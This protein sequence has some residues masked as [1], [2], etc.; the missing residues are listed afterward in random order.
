MQDALNHLR[1]NPT[2]SVFISLYEAARRRA[3]EEL[4]PPRLTGNKHA[5]VDSVFSD[6]ADTHSEYDHCRPRLNT[7]VSEAML[8]EGKT[9]P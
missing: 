1:V 4:S 6:E 8:V 7:E 9:S 3:R 5:L 2:D